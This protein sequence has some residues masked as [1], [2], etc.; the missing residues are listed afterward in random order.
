MDGGAVLR[1]ERAD[2]RRDLGAPVAALRAVALVAE[3]TH[4]FGERACDTPDVPA[5]RPGRLGEAVTRQR[6]YDD[7]TGVGRAAVV[8][9]RVRQSGADVDELHDGA[10]PA[11]REE[12][13]EGIGVR[14]AR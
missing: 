12:Q 10:R 2:S 3:A 1:V 11:V 6:R 9:L 7:V 8:S 14:R 4:Q 13:R 5:P